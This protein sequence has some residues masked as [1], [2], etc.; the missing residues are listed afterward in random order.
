MNPYN[1]LSATISNTC[2][3]VVPPLPSDP[4]AVS[5]VFCSFAPAMRYTLTVTQKT[6]KTARTMNLNSGISIICFRSINTCPASVRILM[7][8]WRDLR[9]KIITHSTSPPSTHNA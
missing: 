5:F 8:T 4:V 1:W 9:R 2:A 7:A 3:V 6:R